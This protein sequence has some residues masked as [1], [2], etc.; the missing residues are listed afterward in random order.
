M[1]RQIEGLKTVQ[2]RRVNGRIPDIYGTV[3]ST[4]DLLCAHRVFENHVEKEIAY[5]CIGRGA[6]EVSDIRDGTTPV[7]DIAGASVAVYGPYTSPNG[8]QPQQV[9]GNQI[10]V[11]VLMT[12][13]ENA[14]T[15][16]CEQRFVAAVAHRQRAREPDPRADDH[17][18]AIAVPDTVSLADAETALDAI[19]LVA[20][21]AVLIGAYLKTHSVAVLLLVA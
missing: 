10:N 19:E 4:P 17:A 1:Q 11:P 15:N 2:S 12:K 7:A 13:R 16:Q 9:I 14:H 5:M 6:Y 18:H 8:G 20:V 21:V 3:R